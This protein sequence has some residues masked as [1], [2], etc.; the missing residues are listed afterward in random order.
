MIPWGIIAVYCAWRALR[1][2]A[3]VRV[4]NAVARAQDYPIEYVE[5]PA[6]NRQPAGERRLTLI[7][8]GLTLDE[9]LARFAARDPWQP[10]TGA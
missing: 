10:Y 3:K 4:E 8:G 7:Q 6:A 2:Y 9:K 1:W 5:P